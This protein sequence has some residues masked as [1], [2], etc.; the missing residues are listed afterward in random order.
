MQSV[1]SSA[2]LP[3]HLM[4][5]KDRPTKAELVRLRATA[6]AVQQGLSARC[7]K[8]TIWKQA[9]QEIEREAQTLDGEQGGTRSP[10]ARLA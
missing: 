6:I 8:K 2:K 7:R 10:R 5:N 3:D 1:C 9:E 4:R